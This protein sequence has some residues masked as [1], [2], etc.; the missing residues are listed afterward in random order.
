MR[1]LGGKSKIRKPLATY[2]ESQRL[3]GQVYFEPFVGGAW[4]L[5]EMS[6]KRI[7]SDGNAALI[8]MYQALQNGW[9]PNE[10]FCEEEYALY[11]DRQD[12]SDPMTAFYGI[13]L[14]FGG[15]WFGG[16]A[17]S[18]GRCLGEETRRGLLKTLPKI[19]SVSFIQG[20][21]HDHSPNNM[22]VYC[23]PPYQSTTTYGAFDGFDHEL[24]WET[25]RHWSQNNTVFVSEYE[26]PHDFVCVKEFVSQ[27]G[28]TANGQR[29][30]RTERLFKYDEL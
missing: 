16:Y 4:V 7:A 14:S 18:T 15:K 10:L 20:L 3:P 23:D 27:M 2:L 17:R 19:K 1:Y 21:F 29:T 8:T 24:F 6:G 26:A 22:L 11:K 9:E 25:M 30:K 5:Q 13:G 28:M 12:S